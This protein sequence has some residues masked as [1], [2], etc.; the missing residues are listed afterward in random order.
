MKTLKF[1]SAIAKN[2]LNG[3]V[4]RTWRLFDDK[5][6]EVDDILQLINSDDSKP[7]GYAKINRIV[8][9]HIKDVTDDD[10]ERHKIYKN[11][12]AIINEF[13]GYYGN[14]VRP[15]S[16]VKIIDFSF[17]GQTLPFKDVK[18][19]THL[20][21]VKIYTDGGSRGN[22]G[23]SAYGFIVTDKAENILKKDGAYLGITTNN[24]AEYQAVLKALQAA[25]NLGAKKV[26]VY[27]DS[28]LVVN[29][30]NGSYKV[31]N[32]DLIPVYQAVKAEVERFQKVTFTYIP[33]AM[34]Q[35][36]DTKVNEIL[37]QQT[38]SQ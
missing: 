12:D 2:I 17:L 33:R 34:N 13:K 32:R 14:K 23:P 30:I 25:H 31:R 11:I 27:M 10:M 21:E 9:K 4:A 18:S 36:A 5:Q 15:E 7:F 16:V 29:Q 8:V 24:Q 6:L 20:T 28:L 38:D 1:K 3:T 22:P 37:D 35:A 19:T 26:D